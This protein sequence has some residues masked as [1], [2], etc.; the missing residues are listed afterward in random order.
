MQVM[1]I[2][3]SKTWERLGPCWAA[4]E[5]QSFKD[6][7]VVFLDY[8]STQSVSKQ[9]KSSLLSNEGRVLMINAH[10]TTINQAWNRAL[11]R[12][13]NLV[14]RDK[15]TYV[16]F[17]DDESR[18]DSIWL[19]SLVSAGDDA[20]PKVGMFA[21][22]VLAKCQCRLRSAGHELVPWGR[23]D[24]AY[25]S[26]AA[27]Q[28]PPGQPLC[29]C[30]VGAMFRWSLIEEVLVH[31]AFSDEEIEHYW[32][33][34]DHGIK[35]RILGWRC[36]LVPTAVVVDAGFDAHSRDPSDSDDR[37]ERLK[38]ESRLALTLKYVPCEQLPEALIRQLSDSTA[39]MLK[40]GKGAILAEA[41]NNLGQKR[42][43][44]LKKRKYWAQIAAERG[45]GTI[46]L[47]ETNVPNP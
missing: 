16:A 47:D 22:K 20:D 46:M 24:R 30:Q 43:S 29:P 6:F 12:I 18:P 14:P 34:F 2:V 9:V 41:F 7:Q 27:D 15:P 35:A 3:V 44:L 40:R 32:S 39:K 1:V 37:A 11:E 4:L 31:E 8:G 28:L 19:Q 42:E 5:G 26:N 13:N 10:D 23:P 17:L 33:C 25:K 21:S 36:N 45:T 38:Q